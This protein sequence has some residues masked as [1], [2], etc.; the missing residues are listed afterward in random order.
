MESSPRLI[1]WIREPV[2]R[3][4]F[5]VRRSHSDSD[6]LESRTDHNRI[7]TIT[8]ESRR[9]WMKRGSTSPPIPS[10]HPSHQRS[11]DAT[12]SPRNSPRFY[13]HILKITYQKLLRRSKERK[14]KQKRDSENWAL[15]F[16]QTATRRCNSYGIWSLNS[17]RTLRTQSQDI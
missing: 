2:L 13:S 1:L 15:P 12:T 14:G 7:L 4:C 3:E 10:T 8:R 6:M 9:L 11:S 17:A 16:P 5:L